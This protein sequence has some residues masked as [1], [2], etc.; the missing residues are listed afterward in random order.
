[1]KLNDSKHLYDRI[2]GY[3]VWNINATI[4]VEH[5]FH[6]HVRIR[7]TSSYR[8]L[9]HC[10]ILD[11]PSAYFSLWTHF[12]P[13]SLQRSWNR[14]SWENIYDMV[15]AIARNFY[16]CQIQNTHF[17]FLLA[18]SSNNNQIFQRNSIW[19]RKHPYV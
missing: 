18:L 16:V 8:I 11:V 6:V 2:I 3:C 17:S 12:N 15:F 13:L 5:G 10:M 1:M 4:I 14:A 7:D 9:R 19:G